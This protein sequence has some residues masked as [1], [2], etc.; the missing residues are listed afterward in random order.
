MRWVSA[1]FLLFCAAIGLAQPT[2]QGKT[3]APGENLFATL[4][5]DV[6]VVVKK[7]ATGS[8]F[9]T[10]TMLSGDYPAKL[11]QDQI[12]MFG[13]LMG[14]APQ[15]ITVERVEVDPE[16]PYLA[17]L[18][19]SFAIHGLID[20][21]E[22]KLRIQ[23]LLQAFTGDHG[24]TLEGWTIIFEGLQP[25]STTVQTY[26]AGPVTGQ[27]R[28]STKPVGTEYRIRVQTQDPAEVSFPDRIA[29]PSVPQSPSPPGSGPPI[30][31]W[32]LVG[33]ATPEEGLHN[34]DA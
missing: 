21:A 9:V 10:I 22:G 2:G 20:L 12:L 14:S 19:G 28:Y 11:L 15:G 18:R 17:F 6:S 7:H 25:S 8:E 5:T 31:I 3:A 13:K 32:I 26:R 27:A 23:P 34:D 29:E 16:K 30:A 4:K 1:A 24:Q 33:V